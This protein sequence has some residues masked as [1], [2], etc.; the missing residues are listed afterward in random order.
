MAERSSSISGRVLISAELVADK[1]LEKS[2]T[3]IDAYAP[4]I[5]DVSRM[6]V[7]IKI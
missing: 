6:M 2:T 5:S 7:D 4:D 3:G 1:M